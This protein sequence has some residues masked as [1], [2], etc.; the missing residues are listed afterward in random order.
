PGAQ[1]RVFIIRDGTRTLQAF[2]LLEFIG[3]AEAYHVAQILARLLGPLAL[4]LRH[5]AVLRDQINEYPQ[6][7]E[8]DQYYHPDRLADAGYV[9]SAEQ[10]AENRDQQPEPQH[11]NEYRKD[12][13]QKV[14]KSEPAWKQHVSPPLDDPRMPRAGREFNLRLLRSP[15]ERPPTRPAGPPPWFHQKSCAA[16]GRRR[17]A[18][19]PAPRRSSSCGSAKTEPRCR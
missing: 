5:S 9:S 12:V 16:P 6:I 4:P 11:E 2:E 18:M 1:P 17:R 8:H 7:G 3:H 14:R 10:I 15:P 19:R 13:G